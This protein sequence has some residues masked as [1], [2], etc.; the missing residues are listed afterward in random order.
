MSVAFLLLSLFGAA[1]TLNALFPR[2]RRSVFAVPSFFAAWPTTELAPQFVVV[3]LAGT[4]VFVW[5]G[6]L[7]EAAGL[8]ALGIAVVSWAGLV[9][10]A[11][12]AGRTGAVVEH[13]LAE[14]LGTDYAATLGDVD[15]VTAKRSLSITRLALALLC[16]RPGS[17]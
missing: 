15:A 3:Q 9:E 14:G 17:R 7:D 2:S 1:L 8:V 10:I 11:R 5:A 12:T 13:A 4:V 6:A 16:P